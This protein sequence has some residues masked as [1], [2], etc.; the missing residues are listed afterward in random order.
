VYFDQDGRCA[1]R[2]RPGLF[3]KE[4]FTDRNNE[5]ITSYD[6]FLGDAHFKNGRPI[7]TTRPGFFDCAYT[8]LDV[9]EED[10]VCDD[11]DDLWAQEDFA[12]NDRHGPGRF[13]RR[14]LLWCLIGYAV[15]ALIVKLN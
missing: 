8:T 14:L 2:S 10:A 13:V 12:E 1:G 11:Y 5:H 7:G 9:E 4:V 6:A 15:I 3:A